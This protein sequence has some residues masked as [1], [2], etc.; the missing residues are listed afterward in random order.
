MNHETSKAHEEYTINVKRKFKIIA[1]RTDIMRNFLP[2][3]KIEQWS[4]MYS[5]CTNT[6]VDINNHCL[7]KIEAN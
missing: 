2:H 7:L 5:L 4:I 6:Q 3:L 1:K